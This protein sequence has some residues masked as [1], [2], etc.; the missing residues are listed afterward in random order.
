M[1]YRANLSPSTTEGAREFTATTPVIDRALGAWKR[2]PPRG[3][4]APKSVAS[5]NGVAMNP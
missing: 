2:Q 5:R 4:A 3:V 1:T